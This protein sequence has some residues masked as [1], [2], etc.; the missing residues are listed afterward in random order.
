MRKYLPA[1]LF[2]TFFFGFLTF[3]L[4]RDVY[5]NLAEKTVVSVTKTEIFEKWFNNFNG[6]D[7]NGI[8]IK[9]AEVKDK[10]VVLNFWATWCAPCK[11]EFPSLNRLETKYKN[12][13]VFFLGLNFDSENAQNSIRKFESEVGIQ[14]PTI[15]DP[16]NKTLKDLGLNTLPLTLIFHNKKLIYQNDVFTNFDDQK[17]ID[18][19]ENALRNTSK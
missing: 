10:V 8:E 16:L 19:I 5:S 15:S 12:K 9:L 17:I 3:Q 1:V 14:F 11:K 18:L 7:L 6:K 2:L 4:C 13:G